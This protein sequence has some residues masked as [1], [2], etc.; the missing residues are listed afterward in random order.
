MKEI[1]ELYELYH[2]LLMKYALGLTRDYNSA[3]ELV[4]ETF[5]KAIMAIHKFR[6]DCQISVW[7]CQ[8]LKNT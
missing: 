3:E 2:D 5:Y 4:Q 1:H 7:L 8:I 6:G